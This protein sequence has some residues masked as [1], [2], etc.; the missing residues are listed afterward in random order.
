MNNPTFTGTPSAPTPTSGTNTTQ[1]AT[2]AFVQSEITSLAQLIVLY[3]LVLLQHL[4]I[5]NTNT[6]QLATTEFITNANSF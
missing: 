2:T 3:L 1:L 5:P 6:T 4:P